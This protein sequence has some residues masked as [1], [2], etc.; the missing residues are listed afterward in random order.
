MPL[1]SR[2][3]RLIPALMLPSAMVN[4]V[5]RADMAVGRLEKPLPWLERAPENTS[6]RRVL[7]GLLGE[8][9]RR[10]EAPPT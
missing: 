1:P 4:R 6:V 10:N 2:T 8:A 7:V 5:I 3:Q 9:A